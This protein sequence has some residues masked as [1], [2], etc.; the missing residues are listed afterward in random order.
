MTNGGIFKENEWGLGNLSSTFEKAVSAYTIS[1]LPVHG[2][3]YAAH[4][5]QPMQT[6]ILDLSI[7]AIKS[8]I[9]LMK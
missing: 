7:Y 9:Q 1:A 4:I 8:S 2:Q 3:K 5:V 6:L